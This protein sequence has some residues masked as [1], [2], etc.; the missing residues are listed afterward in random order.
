M[1]TRQLKERVAHNFSRGAAVYDDHAEE[2]RV[3][4]LILS[5]CIAEKV[6]YLLAGPIL[7][8]GCGTGLLSAELLK[9]L[10]DRDLEFTDLSPGMIASC[11]KKISSS[12]AVRANIR[13]GVRD[14][15]HLV[16]ERHY[17]MICANFSVHWFADLAQGLRGMV[18]ALKPGGTLLC[19]YPGAGSY[20]EWHQQCELLGVPCSANPLP[21]RSSI[22]QIMAGESATVQQWERKLRL[23]FPTAHSFLRHV[24]RTGAGTPTRPGIGP[25]GPLQMR[26]LLRGWDRCAPNGVEI[27]C[28][29]HFLSVERTG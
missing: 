16:H 27:T 14:G 24:K 18:R 12:G 15:E 11:R 26:K 6:D 19:S 1:S 23:R 4:A 28:E 3:A 17:A 5:Q 21:D 2:Q 25:L 20:R 9:L 10:P 7:E 13:Y 22:T 29:I 8:I